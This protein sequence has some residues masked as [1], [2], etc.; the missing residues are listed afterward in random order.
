[1]IISYI[2]IFYP[3]ILLYSI[4]IYL[5]P[6]RSPSFLIRSPNGVIIILS[7]YKDI[8]YFNLII[9]LEIRVN[10][11]TY[12]IYMLA[13]RRGYTLN[14]LY[15]TLFINPQKIYIH[16]L[17]I[18]L[19]NIFPLILTLIGYSSLPLYLSSYL[20]TFLSRPQWGISYIPHIIIPLLI[21]LLLVYL[22]SLFIPRR[23]YRP[24]GG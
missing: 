12:V 1:M 24:F 22:L 6:L 18:L 17:F 11:R 10:I 13:P 9:I 8:I 14:I 3:Y 2:L 19:I 16:I 23:L 15:T 7:I 20:I 21:L 5:I 4:I